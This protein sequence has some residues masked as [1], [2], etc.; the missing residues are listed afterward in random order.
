MAAHGEMRC[1]GEGLM[2]RMANTEQVQAEQDKAELNKES[3]L[4]AC[5]ASQAGESGGKPDDALL[6][7]DSLGK[8]ADGKPSGEKPAGG[9]PNSPSHADEKVL[10]MGTG[11]IPKLILEFAVPSVCGMMVNGA[12][13]LISSIFLGQAMGEL[14]LAVA[15][16]AN[17]TMI[18]FMGL[19]M[20]VGMGGN[21]LCALRLGE[22]RKDLAE[23]TLGNTVTLSFILWA[24][25]LFLAFCPWTVD[26]L[27]TLSSATGDTRPHAQTFVQ[28]LSL[29]F[30]FQC[31][32]AGV[33]N[34]IR[35][36][37]APNRAL[38]TMVIGA[39]SCTGFSFLYVMVLGWG[40]PGSAL[41]TV[42]G[43]AVSAATVVWYFTRTKNVPLRLRLS[44]MRFDPR[45]A[46]KIILL[47][48]ASF[49]V[50]LG[51]FLVG[52]ATNYVLVKYGALSPIGSDD[53]L[54]SIGVVQR[55]AMFSVLPII[56]VAAAIQPLLGFNYG[57]RNIKRVR[58]TLAWGIGVAT[59]I[60]VLFW[61][62]VH[63]FSTELVTLFGITKPA[64]LQFTIFALN[65][66]LIML[67]I[68]GFQIVGAN[69][70]QATGQPIK[71]TLLTLT[72][73]VIFLIPLYFTLP[74]MLPTLFPQYTGLDAVY[75]ACPV[76]DFLAIFTTAVFMVIELRRLRRVERGEAAVRI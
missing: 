49:S 47:G 67:P 15:T 31:V 33:N 69:Y 66:Q 63:L 7:S 48:L 17:P 65:V 12:Y 4:G 38:L 8:P 43:Q 37:G 74:E 46:G 54:A 56:G 34:F 55:I 25:I 75:F 14:G 6:G 41:A 23:R 39:V 32:G 70:F 51:A 58:K 35:T 30:V 64:L 2:G 16:A 29:G 68:V 62:F 11:S 3:A 42:C 18:I 44:E 36:A 50:Q 45:T 22:G 71:S 9:K 10:R 26:A 76:A 73:Q 5:G 28:I 13:N 57:A 19:S 61:A 27:L 59:V 60:S 1:G 72:R 24:L 21:A 52:L 40:V 53:A 20:L